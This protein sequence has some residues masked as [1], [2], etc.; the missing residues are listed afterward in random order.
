MNKAAHKGPH[1]IGSCLCETARICGSVETES[2]EVVARAGGCGEG[3]GS[4]RFVGTGL[5]SGSMRRFWNYI[6]VV[7]AGTPERPPAAQ[8]MTPGSWDRVP[9]QAR[10]GEPASP[11]ACVSAS[12]CVS[13]I[14]K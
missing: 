1:I 11:S 9:H 14:N 12:L 8:A 3:H 6:E 5:D 10:H 7:V 4:F 2:G 13:L